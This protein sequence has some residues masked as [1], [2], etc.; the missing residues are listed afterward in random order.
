M[1]KYKIKVNDKTES[2]EAQE[3]L[4]KMG[5]E[6][7]CFFANERFPRWVETTDDGEE[8]W[9]STGSPLGTSLDGFKE[10]TLAELR[11]LVAHTTG[12]AND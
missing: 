10:L 2:K 8:Y 3:L 9:Y 11:D 7:G 5:Y 1:E 6:I 4:R 12:P